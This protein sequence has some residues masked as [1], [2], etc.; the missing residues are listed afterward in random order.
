MRKRK[1]MYLGIE[2]SRIRE[3]FGKEDTIITIYCLKN[4]YF[5]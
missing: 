2:I 3:E 5:H 1:G 4:I